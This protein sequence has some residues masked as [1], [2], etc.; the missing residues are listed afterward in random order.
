M[1]LKA[2]LLAVQDVALCAVRKWWRPATCV[3]LA[4]SVWVNLVIIPW[5]NGKPIEFTPA[6]AFVGAI[7]A[8]FAIREVGKA[9]GTADK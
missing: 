5:R 9:W 7:T 6:A 4:A 1:N 8:A 3:G 2:H